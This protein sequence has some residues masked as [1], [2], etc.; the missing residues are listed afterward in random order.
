MG[1]KVTMDQ[2]KSSFIQAVIDHGAAIG[3]KRAAATKFKDIVL[4]VT[5]NYDDPILGVVLRVRGSG[6]T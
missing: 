5:E 3:D 4:R 2:L 1:G 6:A